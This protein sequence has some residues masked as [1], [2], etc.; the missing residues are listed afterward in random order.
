MR[1]FFTLCIFLWTVTGLRAQEGL[2]LD[3]SDPAHASRFSFIVDSG[4]ELIE[5]SVSNG[6]MKITLNKKEWHFFQIWVDPLDFVNNPSV[7]FRMKADQ[8][9][10][11]RI[12]VKQADEEELTIFEQ[13]VEP[14]DD[15]QTFNYRI[16]NV[17]PLT[18]TVQEVGVDI[19]GYQVP[20]ATFSG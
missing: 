11:I 19:G 9:T 18:T 6:E 10:P 20:P 13:T 16:D 1:N 14:S 12:W 17:A 2:D 4:G 15:Y 7:S 3:F 8:P 5:K